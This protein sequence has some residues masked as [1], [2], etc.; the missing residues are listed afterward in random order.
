MPTPIPPL[1]SGCAT[2]WKKANLHPNKQQLFLWIQTQAQSLKHL[3]QNVER[4]INGHAAST[5]VKKPPWTPT[6]PY[7]YRQ[8][9]QL[10]LPPPCALKR[11]SF[12]Q[13]LGRGGTRLLH[14]NTDLATTLARLPFNKHN[15]RCLCWS[16]QNLKHLEIME[17][18]NTGGR[19]WNN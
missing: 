13:Q 16:K 5:G 15:I 6:D 4:T 8:K 2:W 1:S 14:S 12:E 9:P 18:A 7:H 3:R 19:T 17:R 11:S 10:G